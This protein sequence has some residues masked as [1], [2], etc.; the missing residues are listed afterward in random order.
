MNSMRSVLLFFF[1]SSRRRHTR[2]TCD[3]SSDVCSSD[4]LDLRPLAHLA[5]AKPEEAGVMGIGPV[6]RELQC[7]CGLGV[8]PAL[9]EQSVDEIRRDRDELQALG[10]NRTHGSRLQFAGPTGA[11][12]FRRGRF[13]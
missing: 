5:Q 9:G 10:S 1:F 13:F 7:C 11:P 8:A 6:V 3:W 2:L 12:W 4:L